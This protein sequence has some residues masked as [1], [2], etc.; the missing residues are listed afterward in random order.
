MVVKEGERLKLKNS[1]NSK[2]ISFTAAM[3]AA[4]VTATLV[5]SAFFFLP[6]ITKSYIDYTGRCGE[7]YGKILVILYAV[8]TVALTA[9]C[10]ILRLLFLVKKDKIFTLPAV[11]SVRALALCCFGECVLFGLLAMFYV[12]SLLIAFAAAFLGTLMLVQESVFRKAAELKEE[13]DFTI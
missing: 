7:H 6:W 5:I 8:L 2:N 9:V 4:R 1:K 3:I 13:N 10:F 12:I 11:N